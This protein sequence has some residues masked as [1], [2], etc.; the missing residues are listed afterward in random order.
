MAG[1]GCALFKVALARAAEQS[2]G[3]AVALRCRPRPAM[4]S[5]SSQGVGTKKEEKGKNIQVVVRCR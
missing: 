5:F 1:P 2:T 4:A 3:S